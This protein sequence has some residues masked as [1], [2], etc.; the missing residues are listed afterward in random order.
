MAELLQR[1]VLVG[2]GT[3]DDVSGQRHR[4]GTQRS[5]AVQ[6]KNAGP[7]QLIRGLRQ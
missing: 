5:D 2:L 4:R 3:V 1:G 7:V 6:N